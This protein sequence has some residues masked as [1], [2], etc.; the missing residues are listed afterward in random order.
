MKYCG[1]E[2]MNPRSLPSQFLILNS[3]FIIL[4]CV[5]PSKRASSEYRL[6]NQKSTNVRIL[7]PFLL[8]PLFA[9]AQQVEPVISPDY[10]ALIRKDSLKKGKP[11]PD[12]TN[13]IRNTDL[14]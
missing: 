13:S 12:T 14:R 1:T 2:K 11:G 10:L 8:L 6:A 4:I 9:P 5:I 3:Q 7:L